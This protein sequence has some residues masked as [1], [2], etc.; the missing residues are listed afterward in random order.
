MM[1]LLYTLRAYWRWTTVNWR[2]REYAMAS[3][4]LTIDFSLP[5]IYTFANPYKVTFSY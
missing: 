5:A 1:K 4:D 3:L 2:S